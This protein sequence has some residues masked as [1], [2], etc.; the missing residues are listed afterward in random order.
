VE[1]WAQQKRGRLPRP[2]RGKPVQRE[3][4]WLLAGLRRTW[5]ERL[6]RPYRPQSTNRGQISE[7]VGQIVVIADPHVPVAMAI[8]I[9]PSAKAISRLLPKRLRSRRKQQ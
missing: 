6:G 8:S 7:F 4:R 9:L 2:S 1:T 3:L 5:T